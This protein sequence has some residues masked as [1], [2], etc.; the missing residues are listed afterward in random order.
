M[1]EESKEKGLGFE[2]V[3]ENSLLRLLSLSLSLSFFLSFFY[4]FLKL[5][6]TERA[7]RCD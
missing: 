5:L 6:L 3:E 7:R 4:L 1:E 2:E